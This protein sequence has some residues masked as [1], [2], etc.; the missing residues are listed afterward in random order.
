MCLYPFISCV[1]IS[2][3]LIDLALIKERMSIYLV[4]NRFACFSQ[5]RANEKKRSIYFPCVTVSRISVDSALMPDYNTRLVQ[6]V[7]NNRS[8][9]RSG[10]FDD[11]KENFAAESL[12]ANVT[13]NTAANVDRAV[14]AITI[15]AIFIVPLVKLSAP[16]WE[17]DR[18]ASIKLLSRSK[19]IGFIDRSKIFSSSAPRND[20][21]EVHFG[22]L[23]AP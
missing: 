1:T 8:L 18:L 19:N 22:S 10:S 23:S 15:R 4:R 20:R 2:C 9:S 12:R 6:S 16:T 11:R 17:S 14:I 7:H 5:S 21:Q 3:V 13:L